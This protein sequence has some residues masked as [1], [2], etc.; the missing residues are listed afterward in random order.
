MDIVCVAGDDHSF[1]HLVWI[2]VKDLFVF[3]CAWL[4]FI[5]IANEINRLAAFAI[6]Q[7][8]FQAAGKTSP[9]AP[10]QPRDPDFFAN[11]F[12]AAHGFAFGKTL[13][14]E[15]ERFLER[16]ITSMAQ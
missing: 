13:W 3:E 1:E 5:G 10:T 15:G 14:R 6:H 4:R 9:A 16:F 2:L 8:P 7:G 12:R 11:L